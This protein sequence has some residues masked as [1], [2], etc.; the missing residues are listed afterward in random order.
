MADL[1]RGGLKAGA[2]RLGSDLEDSGILLGR[3]EWIAQ[4]S[5]A[6]IEEEYP[7]NI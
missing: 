1:G 6:F 5:Q 7:R 2:L 4:N 3:I